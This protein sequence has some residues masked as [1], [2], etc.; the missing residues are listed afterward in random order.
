[1]VFVNA[2]KFSVGGTLRN[3]K[4]TTVPICVAKFLVTMSL[5][6]TAKSIYG[7]Q[8]LSCRILYNSSFISSVGEGI[9]GRTGLCL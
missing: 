8:Y 9:K 6:P 2:G 3:P 4:P 7:G 5:A 1:M